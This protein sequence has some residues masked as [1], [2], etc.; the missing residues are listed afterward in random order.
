MSPLP[1][2]GDFFI[3]CCL[4]RRSGRFSLIII[5]NR[6]A[7]QNR[8]AVFYTLFVCRIFN[9]GRFP[10]FSYHCQPIC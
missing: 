2:V 6:K 8:Y 9:V 10:H 1:V 3:W 4:E 7:V 5:Y